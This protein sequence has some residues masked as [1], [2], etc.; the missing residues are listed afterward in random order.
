[1]KPSERIYE[2]YEK[3]CKEHK[4]QPESEMA[5]DYGYR[6][7]AIIQYLDEEWENDHSGGFIP[8]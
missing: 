1:M 6:E 2:I 4:C 5:N 3:I 8:D 7:L